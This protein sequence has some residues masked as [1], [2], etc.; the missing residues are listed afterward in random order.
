MHTVVQGKH[1]S[2]QV[3][4][5]DENMKQFKDFLIID[6]NPYDVGH[7]RAVLHM[8]FGY[9]VEIRD[10][11]SARDAIAAVQAR[12]P[13]VV[14]ADHLS[15]SDTAFSTLMK[16][17]QVGYDGPIVVVTGLA[18]PFKRH[19]LLNA[20]AADVVIKDDLDSSTLA[21]TLAKLGPSNDK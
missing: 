10:V 14:F 3:A 13:E 11:A 6:D 9:E 19:E 7:L 17:R 12:T 18:D 8:V 16:L 20:G 21:S 1:G 2:G 5:G 15:P 4:N